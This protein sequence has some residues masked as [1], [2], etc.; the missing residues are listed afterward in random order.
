[1]ENFT[2][3]NL[4][5]IINNFNCIYFSDLNLE[6]PGKKN[7]Y[8]LFIVFIILVGWVL[9]N[10]RNYLNFINLNK[11]NAEN[12]NNNKNLIIN[13]K[14]NN[15][16]EGNNTPQGGDEPSLLAAFYKF[17]DENKKEIIGITLITIIILTSYIILNHYNLLNDNLNFYKNTNE[18][19]NDIILNTDNIDPNID[20]NNL[21]TLD[22]PLESTYIVNYSKLYLGID[23]NIVRIDD[24]ITSG[25]LKGEDFNEILIKYPE[26]D[27]K[28][29]IKI[30]E[31]IAVEQISEKEIIEKMPEYLDIFREFLIKI[32]KRR[33]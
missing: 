5:Y 9:L 13:K 21:N 4:K 33:Q 19:Q 3:I 16:S 22:S 25:L 1:M 26:E 10:I 27:Q 7:T 32:E 8:F 28:N 12:K 29:F 23:P 2:N 18:I 14:N 17:V 24:I 6:L 15:E 31:A 20:I 11:Q 30:L